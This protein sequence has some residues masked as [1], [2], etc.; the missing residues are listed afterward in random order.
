DREKWNAE[1]EKRFSGR[2]L[3]RI[4]DR[5]L[6]SGAVVIKREL[7]NNFEK[8]KD[9]GASKDEITSSKPR[10]LNGVRTVVIYWRGPKK[11]YTIIHLNE[12]ATIKKP[13]PSARGAMEKA[14]RARQEEYARV[15]ARELGRAM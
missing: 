4:V 5:A 7:E 9:T 1:R 6:N 13:N 8:F 3:I 11:R 14:L 15:I 10:T 12:F 2:S